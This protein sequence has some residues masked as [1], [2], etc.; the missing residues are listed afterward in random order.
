M[1]RTSSFLLAFLLLAAACARDSGNALEG[2]GTLELVEAD[3]SPT[4]AARIEQLRVEEGQ[5]VRA[6]DTIAILRVPSL[7]AQIEQQGALARS[8]AAQLR[9]LERG[10]RVE[11]I[12]AAR[13][14]LD[15][16]ESDVVRT[17]RDHERSLVLARDSMI[18]A[19]ELDAAASAARTAVARR[20]AARAAHD[21]AVNGARPEEIEAARAGVASATAAER[22][23]RALSSDLVL[24]AP[25]DGVIT[26]RNAEPG[27]VLAAGQSVATVGRAS[28]PWVRVYLGQGATALVRVGQRATG[29]LDDFPDREF[30]GR[31]VSINT[32]AEFTPRVALTEQERADMLFGVK[33]E[34]DDA[35]GTLKAGLPITVRIDSA[36]VTRP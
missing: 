23:M 36:G 27:E 24:V 6:G 14:E 25:F 16:A 34:F 21:R 15:A 33:V 22:G 12:R 31:V 35:S 2:T 28:K 26:S 19:Q 18:S 5:Q 30:V 8:A 10:T 7:G 20:N 32:S 9:Q 13:S 29:K 17:S 11:D 1:K 3:I 4:S